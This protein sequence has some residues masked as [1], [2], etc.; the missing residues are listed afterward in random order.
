MQLSSK[1]QP[2][3]VFLALVER[4]GLEEEY[5]LVGVSF[6]VAKVFAKVFG[7]IL[8]Q[9]EVQLEV[10]SGQTLLFT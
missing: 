5:R 7:V 1:E 6:E 3:E 9:A 8:K 4:V 2:F 10:A